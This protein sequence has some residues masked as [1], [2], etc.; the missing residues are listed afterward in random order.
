MSHRLETLFERVRT[1]AMALDWESASA[2]TLALDRIEAYVAGL[3]GGAGPD[4]PG[5]G[6]AALDRLLGSPGGASEAKPEPPPPPPQTAPQV[7]PAPEAPAPKPAEPE[8]RSP[9]RAAD[10]SEPASFLRVPAETVSALLRASADLST[11]LAAK[12]SAA[13][14]MSRIARAVGD[15]GRGPRR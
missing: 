5:D 1:G 13:E 15:C 11:T 8:R 7:T 14:G 9:E 4:M 12:A 3:D 6:I 2:V 10:A